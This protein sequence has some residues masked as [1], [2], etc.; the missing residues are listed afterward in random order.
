ML[1]GCMNMLPGIFWAVLVQIANLAGTWKQFNLL[2][3]NVKIESNWGIPLVDIFQKIVLLV[4]FVHNSDPRLFVINCRTKAVFVAGGEKFSVSGRA[5]ISPGFTTAMPWLA[6]TD[7][8]LPSFTVGD[9]ISLTEVELYQL[10][11]TKVPCFF[12]SVLVSLVGCAEQ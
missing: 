1:G 11:G 8:S 9:A 2:W 5:V 10:V 3:E 4:R 7:E 12:S 6:V